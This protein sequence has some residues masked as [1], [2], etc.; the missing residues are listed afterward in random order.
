[1]SLDPISEASVSSDANKTPAKK[2]KDNVRTI[3]H[4]HM[5]KL[6]QEKQ[7]MGIVLTDAENAQLNLLKEL[8]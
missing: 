7:N 2:H 5:R 8:D 3:R 6:L 1:M 4:R